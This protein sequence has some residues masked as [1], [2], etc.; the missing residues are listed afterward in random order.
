MHG[1][2]LSH[3]SR[4]SLFATPWT[5]ALQAPLST[6]FSRQEYWSGLPC[7]PPGDLPDP[8]IEPTSLMSALAGEFLG[9]PTWEPFIWNDQFLLF[10]GQ[11]PSPKFLQNVLEQVFWFFSPKSPVIGRIS[12]N[13]PR[14]QLFW[15]KLLCGWTTLGTIGTTVTHEP[16]H[17]WRG[18][19]PSQDSKA[20]VSSHL[21]ETSL[22]SMLSLPRCI[23]RGWP[24]DEL[25]GMR[26]RGFRFILMKPWKFSAGSKGCHWNP[27]SA[28]ELAGEFKEWVG[29][30]GASLHRAASR[31]GDLHSELSQ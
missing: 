22:S 25:L 29:M 16:A 5:V 14:G 26:E 7:S 10:W 17:L 13:I 18:L 4:V 19:G 3:F 23:P 24:V 6:G 30:L 8:G 21:M 20:L 28:G 2:V 12:R 15:V 27:H 11:L 9:S 1:S 31:D